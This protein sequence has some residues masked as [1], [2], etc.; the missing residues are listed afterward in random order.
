[1]V[2]DK[3]QL[4]IL[5]GWNGSHETWNSFVQKAKVFFDVQVI[6]LPC[7]G[8]EPCPKEIWGIEEYADFVLSK[9]K[10][11][12]TKII[13]LGHSF[14]GQVATLFASQHPEL[15]EKLI[16]CGAA[17]VRPE[18]KIKR[19]FFGVVAKVGKNT[20]SLFESKRLNSVAKKVLYHVA[21]SPD[22]TQTSGMKRNIYQKII[23]QDMQYVLSD[24]LMPTLIV[25]GT[26]DK[27]TP[28]R[29]AKK[30]ANQIPNATIQLIHNGTHG[31]HHEK[32]QNQ[33]IEI[34]HTFVG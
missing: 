18:Y 21:D 33:L 9:I 10:I 25:W 14:G 5:P 22:Y 16:L 27:M 26:K 6:D 4:I 29:F 11:K 19:A 7:F 28:L 20:L 1:M 8:D 13:L 2:G 3:Q 32:T 15:I 31:L 23:R 24:I 34:I 17:I 12:N 30:I